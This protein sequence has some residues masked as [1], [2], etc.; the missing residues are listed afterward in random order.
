MMELKMLFMAKKNKVL[1]KKG[2]FSSA[3]ISK[4]SLKMY[5]FTDVCR[6]ESQLVKEL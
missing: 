1:E 2:I 3:F 6:E 4:N 5:V